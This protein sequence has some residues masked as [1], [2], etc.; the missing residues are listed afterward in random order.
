MSIPLRNLIAMAH[1]ADVSRSIAFY[2]RL[3][4]QP[5]NTHVPE[6][7]DAPVWAW[8]EGGAGQLMLAQAGEP[9]DPGRQAVLF[10]LY[11]D[12]IAAVHARLQADGL[13]GGAD[14]VSVLLPAGRVPIDRSRRLL[15]DVGPHV[16]A[17]RAQS[18][19][20]RGLHWRWAGAARREQGA[21]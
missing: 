4:F 13:P 19:T 6:H 18:V 8:L 3:G 1:V 16:S 15:P 10:Y 2:A 14:D 20:C 5:R 17:G 12:D 7:G 21:A 11:F 9:V